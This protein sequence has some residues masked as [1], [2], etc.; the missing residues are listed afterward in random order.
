MAFPFTG[1]AQ[2]PC[3]T[4]KFRL[5][6]IPTRRFLCHCTICQQVYGKPYSDVTVLS[7]A[8]VAV[9]TPHTIEF[10]KYKEG[11]ALDRGICK[12]CRSPVVGFL[13]I[14]PFVRLA[15]VPYTNILDKDALPDP[16]MHIYY[17][18]RVA[19]VEDG[20]PKFEDEKQSQRKAAGL[21]LAG[22]LGF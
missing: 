1:D 14:M 12:E 4:S 10:A 2:C 6:K 13:P 18:T 5:S 7:A 21:V 8:R 11:P 17:G 22:F 16:A 3:G 9:D 19:D 15:F 20:V